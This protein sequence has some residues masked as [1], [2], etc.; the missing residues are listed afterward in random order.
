MHLK[1]RIL[2]EMVS[3][4]SSALEKNFDLAKKFIRLT[5]EGK[6]EVLDK[7]SHDGPTQVLLYIIGKE[8]ALKAELCKEAKVSNEELLHELGMPKGSLLPALKK[9]RDAK[10][11]KPTKTGKL[12]FHAAYPNLIEKLLKGIEAKPK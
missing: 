2:K 4:H 10:K 7:E 1:E 12:S 11:I 8:F 6:V 9:L 3:D 5:K